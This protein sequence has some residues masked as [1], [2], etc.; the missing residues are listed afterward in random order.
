ML[1]EDEAWCCVVF[2]LRRMKRAIK[3]G[4]FVTSRGTER[5]MSRISNRMFTFQTTREV[6]LSRAVT[7]QKARITKTMTKMTA[8]V[9]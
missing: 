3:P 5:N 7:T 1:H 9:K 8:V 2:E 4:L 6:A